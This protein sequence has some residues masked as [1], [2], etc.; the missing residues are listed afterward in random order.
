MKIIVFG[1]AGFL[2]SHI[3]DQLSLKGHDVTIFDTLESPYIRSDQEMIKGDIL[4]ENAVNKAV[5]GCDVVYNLA[6]IA[7]IDE[8]KARPLETA[9]V[10]ILGNTIV[11]EAARQ[12]GVR[13]FV[14]ASSVYVYSDSGSFYK[15]SKKACE[16][17]ISDYYEQYG[18]EYTILRYGSLY[19]RRANPGNSIYRYLKEALTTG[20][21]TYYGSGEEQREFIHVEDAARASADILT[22]EFVNQH[23]ILT[24]QRAM[25]YKDFLEMIQEILG[26]RIGIEYR[27]KHS[28]THY[29]ITPYN[30]APRLGRKYVANTH[31]DI[32]QG[33]MDC[34]SEL[35]ENNQVATSPEYSGV[36]MD[37]DGGRLVHAS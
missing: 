27:K 35:Y 28:E 19:G 12:A 8:S 26:N 7:D 14:F 3:A 22:P 17:F 32:G 2:G 18:L 13:R 29:R 16:Y 34:I 25:R 11:L 9:R 31:I 4:D 24:G 10:N 23:I 30:F 5:S 20:K 1:G 36:S 6:A 33:I 21:I 37:D 15:S